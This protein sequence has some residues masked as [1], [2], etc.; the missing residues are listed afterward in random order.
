MSIEDPKLITQDHLRWIKNKPIGGQLLM[1]GG[2]EVTL[3]QINL[4]SP[5][6]MA[7]VVNLNL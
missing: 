5:D 4:L 1:L 2:R 6:L 7:V 3:A